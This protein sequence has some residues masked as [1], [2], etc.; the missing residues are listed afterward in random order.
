MAVE[1]FKALPSYK[2]N[3]VLPKFEESPENLGLE[4]FFLF[5]RFLVF[6][7]SVLKF[8]L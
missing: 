3:F 6:R 4:W 5:S 1:L 8:F 7:R 2:S